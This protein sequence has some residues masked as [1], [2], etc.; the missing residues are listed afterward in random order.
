M[1]VFSKQAGVDI[2]GKVESIIIDL[3]YYSFFFLNI[4]FSSRF[5][6]KGVYSHMETEK[7][8]VLSTKDFSFYQQEYVTTLKDTQVERVLNNLKESASRIASY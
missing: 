1:A 5:Y 3:A 6:N 2:V 7:V 4:I 8:V